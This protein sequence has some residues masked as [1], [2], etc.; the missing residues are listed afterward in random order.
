MSN[1]NIYERKGAL[2]GAVTLRGLP[3]CKAYSVSVALFPVPSDSS[4]PPF[5]GE[6]P[7]EKY[8]DEVTIKGAEEAEDKPLRFQL[9]RTSGFYYL[10]VGVIAY[11]ER[12][13]KMYAQVERFFPMASPIR[14]EAGATRQVHLAVDWPDI[15]F[16]ELGVYGTIYPQ[17]KTNNDA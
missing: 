6:P 10:D 5:G 3:M 7:A 8:T 14:I 9:E 1:L 15:P 16:D 17:D 13:G 2:A 12:D 11:I 4:P